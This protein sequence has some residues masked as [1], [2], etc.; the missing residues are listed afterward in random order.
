MFQFWKSLRYHKF[1]FSVVLFCLLSYPWLNE[2][3]YPLQGRPI[4]LITG[5]ITDRTGLLSVLWPLLIK[6]GFAAVPRFSFHIIS[7]PL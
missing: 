6:P 5:M 2:T 4:L 3:D 7:R 1:C